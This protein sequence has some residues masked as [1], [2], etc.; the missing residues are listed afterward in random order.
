MIKETELNGATDAQG[1]STKENGR[2]N[3]YGNWY[4]SDTIRRIVQQRLRLN[5]INL[6]NIINE[7]Q[8][9]TM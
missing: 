5:L 1:E 2:I 8:I 3:A 4:F 7:K 6:T 9:R